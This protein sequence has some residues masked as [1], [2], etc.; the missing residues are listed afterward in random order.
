MEHP[1]GVPGARAEGADANQGSGG[2]K[3][4]LKDIFGDDL[5]NHQNINRAGPIPNAREVAHHSFAA[6]SLAIRMAIDWLAVEIF[7][8]VVQHQVGGDLTTGEEVFC[9]C[10]FP[11]P[12]NL[13]AH[14]L[15]GFFEGALEENTR[16]ENVA[17]RCRPSLE[18]PDS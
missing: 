13:N 8:G 6:A 5:I 15:S 14:K 3:V 1:R 7:A 11:F 9:V 2:L 18:R 16:N 17:G 10:A 4:P 12:W